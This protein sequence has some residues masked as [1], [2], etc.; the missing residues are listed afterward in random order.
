MVFTQPLIYGLCTMPGRIQILIA[1]DHETM[2]RILVGLISR[3]PEWELCAEATDGQQAVDFAKIFCPD[4]A[5]LDVQ[6]PRLSGLEAARQILRHCPN[7]IIVSD[8]IHDVD[9]FVDQLKE[10][11]VKGFVDKNRLGTDLLPT[12]EAV[13]KGGTRLPFLLPAVV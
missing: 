5:I 10:I 8:S 2:R 6:M 3:R 13:L 7:A 11:G 12:I 1:D 4:V 9:L